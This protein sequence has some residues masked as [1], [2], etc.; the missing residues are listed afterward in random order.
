MSDES[1]T[2]LVRVIGRWT[3]A[4]LVLN[5]AIGSSVFG[6]PSLISEHVGRAAP[7]A[8]LLAGVG[9]AA[10]M[11]CFAEVGSQF[12]EAGGPYLYA[13][14]AFGRF[15][16]I[17]IA[18][19]TWLVR[20]TAAAANT[21][22]FVIYLAEFW[23]AAATGIP[24][25]LFS[26]LVLAVL[27][28]I[29]YRGVRSGARMSNVFILA[30]L[31]PLTLA[32]I[33]GLTYFRGG[34]TSM[35]LPSA[36]NLLSSSFGPWMD[37][38]LIVVFAYG[39]FEAGL[40]AMGEAKDPRRDVPFALLTGFVVMLVLY[41]LIQIGVQAGLSAPELSKRPLADAVG[42]L[43]GRWGAVFIAVGALVSISGYLGAMMLSVPRLTFALAEQRDFPPIFGRIHPR[44]RTP[45]LSVLIFG[46]LVWALALGGS[47]KWNVTLSAVAR[48]LTYGSTCGAVIALRRKNPDA[49]ALRLPAG[50]WIG[51]AGVLFSLSMATRMDRV[52]LVVMSVTFVI[53]L[54]NWLW[55][56]NK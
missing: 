41:T 14:E 49:S 55:A 12:R 53:A 32:A 52:A 4:G 11:A 45:Y 56:R 16:G 39:G 47:F 10:I 8:Y 31:A 30:K 2:G 54:A 6:L 42:S 38:I 23:P 26:T 9:V 34:V 5:S 40:F 46:A 27:M 37:A 18:W 25:V 20:L 22:L 33:L 36:G 15:A 51:I 1:K 7:V 35:N 50:N 48:L 43:L 17:Q 3:L 13:R 28:V 44:F 19:V 24:R 29:N 21:N